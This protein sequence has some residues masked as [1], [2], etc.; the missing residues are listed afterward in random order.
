M[1]GGRYQRKRDK[2]AIDGSPGTFESTAQSFLDVMEEWGCTWIW[3]DMQL[4]GGIQWLVEAISENCLMAVTDGSFK[5]ELLTDF[6]LAC[7]VLEFTPGRGSLIVTLAE[8]FQKLMPTEENCFVSWKY[9][10][11]L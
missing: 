1:L 6:C 9:I 4:T 3:D 7:V 11:Y 8:Y 5:R 2:Q 10:F